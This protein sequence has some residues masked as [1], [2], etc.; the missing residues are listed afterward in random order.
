MPAGGLKV[1]SLRRRLAAAAI[2]GLVLGAGLVVLAVVYGIRSK[3]GEDTPD[4]IPWLKWI[5]DSPAANRVTSTV[6][7]V[8]WRNWRSP[9]SRFVGV[10]VV[11]LKTGGPVTVHSASVKLAT[12][13]AL[14]E[15]VRSL[16]GPA[17]RR[18]LERL[19]AYQ[20]ELSE[21][22]QSHPGDPEAASVR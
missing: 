17:Q 13:I 10:R 16:N 7:S 14:G 4:E 8:G 2:D 11:E 3:P 12:S 9:G 5:P 19:R 20:S 21:L 15:F 6:L 22:K 1:A 18:T